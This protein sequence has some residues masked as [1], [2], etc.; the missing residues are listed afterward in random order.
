MKAWRQKT[1]DVANVDTLVFKDSIGGPSAGLPI[2][3]KLIHPDV[4]VLEAAATELARRLT[5]FDGVKDID[6]GFKQGKPQ[7]DLAVTPLGQAAG[8]TEAEIG[9]QVRSAFYGAEAKRQQRGLDELKVMV[10]LPE[11]ERKSLYDVQNLMLRTPSGGEIPLRLAATERRGFA[12]TAIQRTD[13]QRSLH[14]SADIDRD[15]TTPDQVYAK[16]LAPDGAVSEIVKK[17]PGLSFGFAGEREEQQNSMLALGLGFGIALLVIYAL[18]AIPFKS[19]LQPVV[20]MLAIPL[21]IACAILGHILTGYDLSMISFMGMIA[22]SGV[23]VNDSIVM[24][25]TANEYRRESGISAWDAIT[26]AAT[27][28]FRP[29]ML[30]SVT[31]FGGLAPMIMETSVQAR[32]LIPMAVSLGFGVILMLPLVYVVVPGTYLIMEDLKR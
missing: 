8:L 31:T 29:I 14:V 30:T 25:D 23:I 19:Y 16:L 3:L 17:Y 32:F 6:P 21:G 24:I 13:E 7:I 28:R 2:D 26:R 15:R 9:R 20:V 12:F 1:G 4:K 18:I 27:R 10:R 11:A 5:E 22:L